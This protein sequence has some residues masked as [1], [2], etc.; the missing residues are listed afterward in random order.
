MNAPVAL[1]IVAPEGAPASSEN[2]SDWPASGSDAV[3]VNANNVN[4]FTVLFPIAARTGA[5]PAPSAGTIVIASKSL[6]DGVPLSVTRI[7]TG[8][9]PLVVGVQLKAPV[10]APIV[11]PGGA[12]ASSEKVKVFAGISESV[13]V[14]V[15]VVGVPITPVLFPI[16]AST[17]A[18][19]NSFTVT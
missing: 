4:S 2:V 15:K 13:A 14:A 10:D 12:P 11:A 17:G 19:L 8:T 3:A 7:V 6:N 16:A 5:W 9:V 18:E 1:W